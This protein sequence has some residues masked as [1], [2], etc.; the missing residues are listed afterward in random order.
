MSA[1][2]SH[3]S[4]EN[5]YSQKTPCAHCGLP[6]GKYPVGNDPYFCC[7]GCA[8]VHEALHNAGFGNT[9]YKLQDLAPAYQGMKPA[10]VDDDAIRLAELDTSSFLDEHTRPVRQHVKGTELFLEGVHCAACVWLV[11]RMPF[12]VAGVHKARLDLPRAR[13]YLEFTPG[14]VKLSAIA[15]W[16][17][18]FGYAVFPVHQDRSTQR[19]CIE[20]SLLIKAGICWA[21]AGNVMLFAFALYSGLSMSKDGSLLAGARWASFALALIATVYGGSEF[22]RKAWASMKV[23]WRARNIKQLHIDTP[24]SLGI[25]VGFGHSSWATIVGRGE[26]WFDSI[27]VLIAALLTARW[28]QL[29]SRRIAGDASDQ[30]LSMIPSMARRVN[31]LNAP[32]DHELVRVD[33]LGKKDVIEV[34]AG[35]VFPVDGFVV[36]GESNLNNA[37]LTGESRPESI[38]PGMSVQAGATNITSPVF[39]RVNA[40]GEETRVGKLL[41]WIQ[42][43]ESNKAD[44]VLLADRLSSY[45]VLGLLFLSALTAIVWLQFAPGEAAQ[46]VVALLV[47]SC[48]CAL[49]MATPLAMAIASGRAARK[50]IFI[51]SDEAIQQLTEVDTVVLDKTGTLTNGSLTLIDYKGDHEA[52][53]LAARLESHSN[54]PIAQALLRSE[55]TCYTDGSA[56]VT[57]VE[58]VAGQGIKGYVAGHRIAIGRP[59]WI[60]SFASRNTPLE[61]T[62]NTYLRAG[63]TPVAIAM[64]G[65]FVACMALGDK[66]RDE[67]KAILH[68]LANQ[69]KDVFILSG[70][71][72][73]VVQHVARQ[74]GIPSKQAIGDAS[75]EDKKAFIERLQSAE[76]RTVAMIGDG[77][78][79]AA[80]LKTAHVGV[81]VH[82]GAS[83]SLVAADV[84]MTSEGLGAIATLLN[85]T[86][87]VM[88]VIKRNL[89]ISLAYNLVGASA[90]I[91]GLVSPLV[92]AIA[93]PLSS[94]LVIT[95]SIA[96]QSFV[97]SIETIK[98]EP[99]NGS[100]PQ[101]TALQNQPLSAS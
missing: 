7:T 98:T 32:E 3:N 99:S 61:E 54:H 29:R 67:A 4:I 34:P 95:S 16:L 71:H 20:Q 24:I 41:A 100:Q 13:L 50:G 6:V 92:A 87:K 55:G 28:L 75:P 42:N 8:M 90:A 49:G 43:Q 38:Q 80:A 82:G 33:N 101:P 66:I 21:I 10:T 36:Q 65:Q 74:L 35:E 73:S 97:S 86:K 84:F 56:L 31:N 70:D 39:I 91:L 27:T 51:K 94:L 83:P 2:S 69:R 57:A 5:G 64:D 14:E 40:T 77:V 37:V 88:H 9:F 12:E 48:P 78:N 59:A 63:Y 96:Q 47:I 44:V 53:Q 1:S 19:S 89:G 22:F 68:A 45:F 11:E 62:I 46:H 52:V 26:I 93:M 85:G 60:Q 76:H 72:H 81:A 23:A 17:A 30:L 15:Q 79:D 25:L 58:A 18:Q